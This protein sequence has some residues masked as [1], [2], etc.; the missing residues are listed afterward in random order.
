MSSDDP[1]TFHI[2]AD[3]DGLLIVN[4]YGEDMTP[5]RRFLRFRDAEAFLSA[6]VESWLNNYEP[7][8]PPGFEAGFADNH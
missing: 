8:D 2:E 4:D 6:M 5:A 1:R 7:P 3:K